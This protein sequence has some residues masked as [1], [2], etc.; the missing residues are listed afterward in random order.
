M[1][2][3]TNSLCAVIV[4]WLNASQRS[5]VAVGMNTSAMGVF[6]AF[7]NLPLSVTL[8]LLIGDAIDIVSYGDRVCFSW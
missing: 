5:Q 6:R 8:P 7:Y 2:I 4:M 3:S 1:D